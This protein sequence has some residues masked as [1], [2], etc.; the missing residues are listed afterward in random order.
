MN[1]ESKPTS[2]EEQRCERAARAQG[3][4]REGDNGGIIYNVND[5]DSWKA[6]VS[7]SPTD[8]PVYDS[9]Q[10]CCEQEGIEV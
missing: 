9:W 6:A 10:E 3:W 5:Y 7:W 8:G 2:S 4:T 1:D